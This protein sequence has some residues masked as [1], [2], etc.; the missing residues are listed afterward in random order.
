MKY[1]GLIVIVCNDKQQQRI[2]VDSIS[3]DLVLSAMHRENLEFMEIKANAGD[4]IVIRPYVQEV[5]WW[6]ILNR[7]WTKRRIL[8]RAEKALKL[9]AGLG[10]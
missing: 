5:T 3:A 8:Q 1:R 9:R 6:E 7:R 4:T 2:G 10:R